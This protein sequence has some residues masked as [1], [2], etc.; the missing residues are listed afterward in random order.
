[1]ETAQR[2]YKTIRIIND[3][4]KNHAGDERMIKAIKNHNYPRMHKS[5]IIGETTNSNLRVT[6]GCVFNKIRF[7]LID[8]RWTKSD[9]GDTVNYTKFNIDNIGFDADRGIIVITD[10]NEKYI[11]G[12]TPD[13]NEALGKIVDILAVV[14]V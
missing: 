2:I 7:E 13:V 1:M 10:E 3:I 12:I 11:Y 14:Y 4:I 9:E 6:L 5:I 8:T